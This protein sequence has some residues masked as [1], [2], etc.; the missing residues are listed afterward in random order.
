ML[1]LKAAPNQNP[2]NLRELKGILSPLVDLWVREARISYLAQSK[3]LFVPDASLFLTGK[4]EKF[5][6][7][8]KSYSHMRYIFYTLVLSLF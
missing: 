5:R 4:W 3:S 8:E 2:S 6:L 1:F 7:V